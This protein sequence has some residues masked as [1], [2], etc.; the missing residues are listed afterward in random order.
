[1]MKERIKN[2][3]I[4]VLIIIVIGLVCVIKF[5]PNKKG[6]VLDD[7]SNNSNSSSDNTICDNNNWEIYDICSKNDCIDLFDTNASDI[8]YS[9]VQYNNILSLA[10]L[11]DLHLHAFPDMSTYKESIA[12]KNVYSDNGKRITNTELLKLLGISMEE[13]NNQLKEQYL[14]YFD[15][16]NI[17]YIQYLKENSDGMSEE[18]LNM[19]WERLNKVRKQLEETIYNPDD[20]SIYI[21]SDYNLEFIIDNSI[22]IKERPGNHW[23]E[24]GHET[25]KIIVIKKG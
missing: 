17:Q 13:F 15:E 3:I 9:K 2:I 6:E 12:V 10:V 16:D 11:V 4:G 5:T 20:Y 19:S 25:S 22:W 18:I 14:K 24:R 8:K 7:P 23:H 1:M 21:N